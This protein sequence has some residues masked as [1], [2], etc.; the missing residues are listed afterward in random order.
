MSVQLN[1]YGLVAFSKD[2][3][4]TLDEACK[5]LNMRLDMNDSR[6]LRHAL[7]SEE[8]RVGIC[9]GC[10]LLCCGE[11]LQFFHEPSSE[12]TDRLLRAFPAGK[13]CAVYYFSI[14]DLYGYAYFENGKRERV[15]HGELNEVWVDHGNVLVFEGPDSTVTRT[16]EKLVGK[17]TGEELHEL[18][19][20]EVSMFRFE[21][22]PNS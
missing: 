21:L 20:K 17:I 3:P 16:Q 12:L 22:M 10:L 2:A 5:F 18:A 8:D 1:R 15:K 19:G 6:V 4:V 13:G 14:P 7:G 11:N 9:N